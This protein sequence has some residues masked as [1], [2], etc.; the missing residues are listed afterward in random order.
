MIGLDMA[1]S[2]FQVQAVDD[3]GQVVI[4]HK[5]QRDDVLTFFKNQKPC[6]V[7]MEA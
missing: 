2:V 7:A 6:T 5:L 3:A 4:R 1:R